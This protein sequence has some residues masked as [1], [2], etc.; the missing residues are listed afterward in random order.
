VTRPGSR[1]RYCR[2]PPRIRRPPAPASSAGPP[3]RR[4]LLSAPPLPRSARASTPPCEC[5]LGPQPSGAG[6]LP[7]MEATTGDEVVPASE[8]R[9]AQQQI[10]SCSGCWARRRSRTSS[11]ARPRSASLSRV[12]SW[13]GGGRER[14]GFDMGVSRPHLASSRQRRSDARHQSRDGKRIVAAFGGAPSRRRCKR[15]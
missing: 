13:P 7:A 15:S 5:A 11:Y 6:A 14:G 12:T 4:E 3:M 10:A 9:A 1:L 8:Y 2:S